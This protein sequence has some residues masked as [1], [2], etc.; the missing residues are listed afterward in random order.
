VLFCNVPANRG[1][2]PS[3]PDSRPAP[4]WPRAQDLSNPTRRQRSTNSGFSK[5]KFD[6]AH[7]TISVNVARGVARDSVAFEPSASRFRS[8]YS[9]GQPVYPVSWST[10]KNKRSNFVVIATAS[11]AWREA[12]PGPE[13]RPFRL[14]ST[15]PRPPEIAA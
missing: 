9:G 13:T 12:I 7:E 5:H 2:S 14:A 11:E 15:T 6:R 8:K 4:I 3:P 1:P 10:R